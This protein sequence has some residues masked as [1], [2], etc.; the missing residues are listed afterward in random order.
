MPFPSRPC[1]VIQCHRGDFVH[2]RSVALLLTL[3]ILLAVAGP[4]LAQVTDGEPQY[5]KGKILSM[6]HLP[7]SG[8]EDSLGFGA[9]A[10]R[11]EVEIVS[12]IFKGHIAQTKHFI[13]GTPAYDI[14]VK[15]G[16]RVLL[17][18]ETVQGDIADVYIADSERDRSLLWFTLLLILM[19]SI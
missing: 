17:V 12:G 1:A 3:S 15:T 8:V 19:K 9:S 7:D 4:V 11:V 16:D 5:A 10:Y 13:T 6:E 14:H 2:K 18:I